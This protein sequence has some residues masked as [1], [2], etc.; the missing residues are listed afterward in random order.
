MISLLCFSL[1][2][3]PIADGAASY[4][5]RGIGGAIYDNFY[6]VR[7]TRDGGFIAAGITASFGDVSGSAFVVKFDGAGLTSWQ[8]AF[9][10]KGSDAA[11]EVIQ[12]KDG[13]YLL[14]GCTSSFG[15]GGMDAW[16]VKLSASGAVVWQ[17]AYGGTGNEEFRAI[18]QAKDGG[19]IA[20]GKTSSYGSGKSDVWLVK[21]SATGAVRWQKAVGGAD[22]EAAE[23]LILTK[24]GGFAVAGST[25]S[26]GAGLRDA[27]VMK[28]AADGA[29]AWHRIYGSTGDD[30]A[31]SICQ[32]VDQGFA[33][34]GYYGQPS[35]QSDLW[36]ARLNPSGAVLWSKAIGGAKRDEGHSVAVAKSGAFVV[37]GTSQ[38]FKDAYGDGWIL[39]FSA[40]GAPAWQKLVGTTEGTDVIKAVRVTSDGGIV[41]CGWG[42]LVK[43][44]QCAIFLRIAAGGGIDKSCQKIYLDTKAVAAEAAVTEAPGAFKIFKS[45]GKTKATKATVLKT[46][47][48]NEY[49][50]GTAAK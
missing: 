41:A 38:S 27:F 12:T 32:T 9:N 23:D 10:G 40:A 49:V 2:I 47:A 25:E 17:K 36:L 3:T 46:S 39:G 16:V 6:D 7:Q 13:G 21:L 11:L 29:P 31:L 14:A 42:G 45:T 15:S 5:A 35:S 18:R 28:F 48:D 24:D 50:C 43:Y 22:D 37:S 4:W 34:T 26:A 30:A 19:Y 20:A 1:L 33:V 44:N 8:K